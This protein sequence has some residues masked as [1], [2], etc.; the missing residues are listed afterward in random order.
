MDHDSHRIG[1]QSQ[2]AR[3]AFDRGHGTTTVRS[4][5]D[6]EID[7]FVAFASEDR[8]IEAT[9]SAKSG[10]DIE[11]Y[12]QSQLGHSLTTFETIYSQNLYNMFQ[13]FVQKRSI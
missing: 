6:I 9:L 11:G 1:H 13:S 3:L 8:R 12:G 10:A 4:S 5:Q 2:V 7:P